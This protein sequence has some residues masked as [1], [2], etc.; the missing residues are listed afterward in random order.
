MIYSYNEFHV[1]KKVRDACAFSK[2]LYTSSGN[3]I[4]TN[5]SGVRLFA[6]KLND[7]LKK[8][9]SVQIET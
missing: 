6:D 2:T 5:I 7:Y 4:L 9:N 8:N 1:S 3:V